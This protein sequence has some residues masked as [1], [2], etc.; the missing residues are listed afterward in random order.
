MLRA[1]EAEALVPGQLE[2][3]IASVEQ[4]AGR[5]RQLRSSPAPANVNVDT[6]RL[7]RILFRERVCRNHLLGGE[8]FGEPSWDM[9][10]DLYAAEAEGQ[11]ICISSAC[12][13]SAVPATTALRYIATLERNGF[14]E[15][16]PEPGDKRRFNLRL[17][18]AG[19][20]RLTETL[21]RIATYRGLRMGGATG[22]EPA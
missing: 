7:A 3:L 13:A 11:T 17:T 20:S 18:E 16:L 19:R 6:A 2:A 10:L 8:L 9:L 5:L 22:R 15:R 14:I 21:E 12:I 1:T 4:L